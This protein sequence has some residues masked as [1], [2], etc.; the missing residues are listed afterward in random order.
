VNGGGRVGVGVC[1]GVCVGGVGVWVVGCMWVCVV[2]G[3]YVG[4]CRRGNG[5]EIA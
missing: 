5:S 2:V 4:V 1:V 3:V